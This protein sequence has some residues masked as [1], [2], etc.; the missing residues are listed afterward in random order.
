MKM[1]ELKAEILEQIRPS[2]QELAQKQSIIE[3]MTARLKRVLPK[4]VEVV[5]VGSTARG[6]A[7]RESRDIDLFMLFPKTYKKEQMKKLG[8]ELAKKAVEPDKW[9]V[10]YAEHPYLRTEIRGRK[11]E[12]VPAFKIA[13]IG[14]RETAVDRSALHSEYLIG[15]LTERL[16]D[17]VKLLKWWLREAGLYGAELKVGGFSGYLCELL[18]MQYGS[19]EKALEAMAAW[20]T[21]V[22]IDLEKHWKGKKPS[23]TEPLVVVDPVDPNRNVAA[24][25]T[26]TSV[27]KAM[28]AARQFLKD[29]KPDFFKRAYP[30]KEEIW[31]LA[32][33]RGTKIYFIEFPAPDVVPDVLWPQLRRAGEMLHKHLGAL[34]FE[35]LNHGVWS[36]EAKKC[37][38]VFEFERANLPKLKTVEGPP[39]TQEKAVEA[40]RAKHA[41]AVMGPWIEGDRIWCRE[42]RQYTT[43]R[44]ALA[45]L[46][47]ELKSS[48]PSYIAKAM[49]KKVRIG[50]GSEI[51]H[52]LPQEELYHFFV[53]KEHWIE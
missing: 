5:P 42:P 47:K 14:E 25:V 29:P 13:H 6:T 48:L 53:R 38:M 34:D 27:S 35:V 41:H 52:A 21:P 24:A 18:T 22:V 3:E 7:L 8:L 4:G 19:F 11:V 9:Q 26:Q 17:E 46:L 49:A 23:F 40:F 2:P 51:L 30:P 44:R 32:R 43:V 1:S 16:Q 20:K 36:D 15:K 37:I 33:A 31:S 12:L 45:A 10:R 39:I 28:M 50:S